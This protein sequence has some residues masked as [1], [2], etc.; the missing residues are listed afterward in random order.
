MNQ[1]QI[2]QSYPLCLDAEMECELLVFDPV[3]DLVKD[4]SLAG[5]AI[6]RIKDRDKRPFLEVLDSEKNRLLVVSSFKTLW[7]PPRVKPLDDTV[8]LEHMVSYIP[9]RIEYIQVHIMR[10]PKSCPVCQRQPWMIKLLGNRICG[11][12]WVI[13]SQFRMAAV[14]NSSIYH[15]GRGLESPT[16]E[17]VTQDGA[18]NVSS[19]IWIVRSGLQQPLHWRQAGYPEQ[20]Q[21]QSRKMKG[22]RTPSKKPI[23]GW[24]RLNLA[25]LERAPC[26][27]VKSMWISLSIRYHPSD[28]QTFAGGTA[29]SRQG[30]T[31][32]LF[33]PLLSIELSRTP[34]SPCTKFN[35]NSPPQWFRQT[36]NRKLHCHLEIPP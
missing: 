27:K 3:N 30:P 23:N 22:M 8:T 18:T 29:G 15:P 24:L 14:N 4:G 10:W 20:R 36:N 31:L 13:D 7:K 35:L 28:Q 26:L 6:D 25:D 2:G 11:H 1:I 21:Q 17:K 34:N 19:R 33:E 5:L 32:A 16:Q 12:A 9:G